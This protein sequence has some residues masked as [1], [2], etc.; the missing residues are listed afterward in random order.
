MEQKKNNRECILFPAGGG[1]GGRLD[2]ALPPTP[3]Q[4]DA[5]VARLVEKAIL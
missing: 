2:A 5:L 3:H 1:I 4:P